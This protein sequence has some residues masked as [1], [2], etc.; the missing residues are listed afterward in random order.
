M[1]TGFAPIPWRDGIFWN[2]RLICILLDMHTDLLI[3]NHWNMPLL[4]KC[5]KINVIISYFVV[6]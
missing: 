4:F 5:W 2:E 3:C 6:L 1:K